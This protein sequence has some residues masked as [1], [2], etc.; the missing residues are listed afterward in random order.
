MILSSRRR[1]AA[2]LVHEDKNMNYS[3]NN[4]A[5]YNLQAQ[6]FPP[7]KTEITV[8]QILPDQIRQMT[9]TCKV[10]FLP[11]RK[12]KRGGKTQSPFIHSNLRSGNC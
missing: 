7:G 4:V 11:I 1:A 3:R 8:Q 10:N 5:L 9:Q 2:Y 6:S 12:V